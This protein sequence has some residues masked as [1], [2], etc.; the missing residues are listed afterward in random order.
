MRQII[1]IIGTLSAAMFVSNARG[2][3]DDILFSN[4]NFTDLGDSIGISG[5]LTGDGL[6]YKNNTYSIFCLKDRQECLIASIEQIGDRQIG[7]LDYAY[8]I[9]I[10]KWGADEV[11]AVQETSDLVCWKT[12][13]T[14]TRKTETTLWV[15]EPIN[16]SR[17]G[18]QKADDKIKRYA[19]DDSLGWKKLHSRQ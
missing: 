1:L 8:S 3:D 4:K 5:T 19:I 16:R 12:T 10:A 13:I 17:S 11:V 9:P 7:R 6:A 15:E 18:C 14:I 2:S